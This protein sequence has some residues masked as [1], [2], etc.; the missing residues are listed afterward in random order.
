M[1]HGTRLSAIQLMKRFVLN[2]SKE[3]P[4]TKTNVIL[5]LPAKDVPEKVCIIGAGPSG[6]SMLCWV[7]KLGREGRKVPEV[8][9]YEKQGNWGGQW[10]NSWR[11]GLDEFGEP[12]HGSMY[13]SVFLI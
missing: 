3:I 7:S 2:I 9:C 13:R 8:I 1:G 10:N 4:Q 12:V 6:L 11:T 5:S